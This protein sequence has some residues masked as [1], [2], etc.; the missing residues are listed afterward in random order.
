[1]R[2]PMP[3]SPANVSGLRPPGKPQ[4]G[5]LREPAREER[6]A[7]I[8]AETQA[9]ENA[10]GDRD[11]VL[12]RPGQLDADDVAVRVDP[13][14]SASRRAAARLARCGRPPAAATTA[15]G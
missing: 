2:S 11:H 3:A 4:P 9:L 10:G 15:V 7:R 12:E 13:E 1:M 14:A 6:R 8:V 5:D